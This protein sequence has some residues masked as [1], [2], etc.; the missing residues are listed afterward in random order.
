MSV[1]SR[2]AGCPGSVA[3]S[4]RSIYNRA[5]VHGVKLV[6]WD[7]V[8]CVVECVVLGQLGWMRKGM[9]N[10]DGIASTQL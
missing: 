6:I 9:L 8:G 10:I 2:G 1:Y 5:G 7:T 4:A 3:Q